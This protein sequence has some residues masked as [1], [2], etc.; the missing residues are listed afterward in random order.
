MTKD[1]EILQELKK[2]RESVEKA[3]APPAPKGF[4]NEFKDFLSKYKI[5]GLAIGFIIGLYL[6]T[7][8]QSLVADLLL[9]A[10]GALIPGLDN[11]A[12]MIV[13]AAGQ[14]F[15]VGN[16]LVALITFIIV[17]LIAFLITKIAKKM[18]ID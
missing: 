4:W 10:I 8:V 7:L 1:D 17:A 2:I 12:T 9:P 5:L 14:N 11:L 13:T 18:K 3:P 6:G 15:G 16:F